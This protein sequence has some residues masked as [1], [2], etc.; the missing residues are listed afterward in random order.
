MPLGGTGRIKVNNPPRSE[1]DVIRGLFWWGCLGL[2][3]ARRRR[4]SGRGARHDETRRE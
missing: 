3:G 2:S 1:P 4:L